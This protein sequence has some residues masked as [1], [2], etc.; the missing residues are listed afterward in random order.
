MTK[1]ALLSAFMFPGLGQWAAGRRAL[2]GAIMV[3]TSSVVLSPFLRFMWGITHPPP[4][5]LWK[6]TQW[7]CMGEML[8]V[9]W[10]STWPL[11]AVCLPLLAITWAFAVWHANR[12]T[13]PG[14]AP[15]T[16]PPPRF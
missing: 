5:D 16:N 6:R 14:E 12:L 8:E 3:V 13:I 7:D 4:C 2:G 1:A 10:S 9:T 15:S 11:L